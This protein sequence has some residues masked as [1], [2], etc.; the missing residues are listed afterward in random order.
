MFPLTSDAFKVEPSAP[1]NLILYIHQYKNESS[2]L[3]SLFK[4]VRICDCIF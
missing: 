3:N 4:F 1:T 2:G